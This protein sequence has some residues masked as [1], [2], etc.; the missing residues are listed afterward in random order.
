[1][2]S[3]KAVGSS[4]SSTQVDGMME[5]ISLMLTLVKVRAEFQINLSVW[6][7]VVWM[8]VMMQSSSN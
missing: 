2:G 4:W 5:D 3:S 7:R 1:M 6:G 8:S